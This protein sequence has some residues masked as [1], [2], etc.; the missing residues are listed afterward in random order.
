MR[1]VTMM[2]RLLLADNHIA[3]LSPVQVR[4]DLLDVRLVTAAVGGATGQRTIGITTHA[5]WCPTPAQARFPT[6]LRLIREQA[7]V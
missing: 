2:T 4:D 1:S 7:Q 6:M 5:G 3:L